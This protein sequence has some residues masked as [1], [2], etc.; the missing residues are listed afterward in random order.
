LPYR[1]HVMPIGQ[2]LGCGRVGAFFGIAA[3]SV[4]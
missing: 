1:H 2:H 3:E 4:R